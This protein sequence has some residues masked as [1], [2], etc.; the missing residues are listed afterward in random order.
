MPSRCGRIAH[1]Q[2]RGRGFVVQRAARLGQ[3]HDMRARASGELELV[4]SSNLA[5]REIEAVSSKN[6]CQKNRQYALHA[7]SGY[8]EYR[9]R[10]NASIML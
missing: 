10:N 3:L 2:E 1:R 5:S 6:V 9:L 7:Y 8:R 4:H